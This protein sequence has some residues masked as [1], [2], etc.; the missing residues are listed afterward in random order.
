MTEESINLSPKY[1]IFL[2]SLKSKSI[3]SK[4]SVIEIFRVAIT[5]LADNEDTASSMKKIVP[6]DYFIAT[7]VEL[8]RLFVLYSKFRRLRPSLFLIYFLSY[9]NFALSETGSPC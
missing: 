5:A 3:S 6:R 7:F 8:T 4:L 1:V 2:L 9:L